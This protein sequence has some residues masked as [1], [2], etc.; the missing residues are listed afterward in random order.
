MRRVSMG[1]RT[2]AILGGTPAFQQLLHVG[3]PN[4]GDRRRLAARFDEMLDRG[5]LSNNGPLVQAFERE[6]VRRV[7]T[8][9]CIPTCNATVALEVTIRALGLGG[10]VIVPSF[11][12]VATAHALQIQGITP[13]FCDIDPASHNIDPARVE[14]LITP[15]T[16]GIL[17]VHL[18]G[19]PCDTGALARIAAR[20]G[21]HLLFD[22]AHAFAASHEKTMIGHFGEAEIF[23]FHATKFINTFEG[24]AVATNS[25]ALAEKVR[26]MINFGFQGYDSVIA[27]GTNGKM[28]E[29]SA[30][31][32]LTNLESLE[33]F[34]AVNRRNYEC[35]REQLDGLDAIRL[36]D[37]HSA[38]PRNYQHV[39]AEVDDSGG[40]LTRDELLSVLHA[41]NVL[42]RRYFYPGCH[43]MAPYQRESAAPGVWLPNTDRVAARVLSLPTGCAVGPHDIS[44]VGAVIHQA[45]AERARVR[46]H[47]AQDPPPHAARPLATHAAGP[48]GRSSGR[49]D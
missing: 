39:I 42:A 15:R 3:R 35:Y 28:S 16:T 5:W 45:L 6:L 46:A 25:D 20:H 2:L 1:S 38:E 37:M 10:E 43:R 44:V 33:E 7:G 9:H 14:A 32:G 23:S 48:P 47:L 36:L 24:G 8:R 26:R 13:V 4:V 22:A 11:T 30:A 40:G 12:F 49:L 18:W 17:G 21:L 29:A 41:E 19:R 31:M 34:V 27:L